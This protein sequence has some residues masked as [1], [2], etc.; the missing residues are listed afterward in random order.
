MSDTA[1]LRKAAGFRTQRE[2][3]EALDKSVATIGKY[4]MKN[5]GLDT[6]RVLTLFYKAFAALPIEKRREILEDSE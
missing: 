6:P 3:A 1:R 4:E 5:G 2:A